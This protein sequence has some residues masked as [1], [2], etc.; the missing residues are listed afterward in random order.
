M[1][2][3]FLNI[4]SQPRQKR[5]ERVGT[6]GTGRSHA[7]LSVPTRVPA[8]GKTGNTRSGYPSGTGACSQL[9]PISSQVLGS[10]GPN[11]H[12]AVPNVSNVPFAV[13]GSQAPGPRDP[14]PYTVAVQDSKSSYPPDMPE[15]VRLLK[16]Q[17]R[18]PPVAITSW[19][20]VN[21]VPQF[22]ETTLGQLQAAMIG[23]N[24]LAGNWSVRELVDRL[25]Q[26]GVKVSV[27]DRD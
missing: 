12:E 9:F 11:L 20:V 19:A 16:W 3:D 23:N 1:N 21:D 6:L 8:I 4:L 15:T 24:W 14:D 25:E 13:D 2:L 26:V 5:W 18:E 7:G 17:P 22:I 10:E 27:E